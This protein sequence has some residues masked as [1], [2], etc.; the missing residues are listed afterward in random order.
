[1]RRLLI[2][3]ACLVASGCAVIKA[4]APTHRDGVCGIDFDVPAGWKVVERSKCVVRLRPDG[5]KPDSEREM[6]EDSGDSDITI[7]RYDGSLEDVANDRFERDEDGRWYTDGRSRSYPE[8]TETGPLRRLTCDT[9]VGIFGATGYQGLG[10]MPC[11]ILDDRAGHTFVVSSE[12]WKTDT[13]VDQV[14]ESITESFRKP[15]P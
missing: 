5:W 1:M 11:V 14:E 13:V 4:S 8:L 10:S 9:L 3:L 15:A 6:F 7:T 12:S 2:S